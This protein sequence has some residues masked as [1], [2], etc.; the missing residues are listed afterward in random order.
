MDEQAFQ[1]GTEEVELE[2]HLDVL[3][4]GGQRARMGRALLTNDRI[5][6]V[7][8]KYNSGMAA[9]SGGILAAL[10]T[11][12]LQKKHEDKGPFL[13]LPLTEITRVAR[14]KKLLN[15]DLLVFEAGGV[16]RRFNEAFPKWADLL[17]R[18]LVERHG[19][20]VT[21]EGSDAWRVR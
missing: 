9:A 6:F 17:R 11:D 1:P 15:K 5:V 18:L 16:E 2:D 12:R 21:E 14:A 8:Q 4:G 7:D 20:T 19:K 13:D 3:I 10:L